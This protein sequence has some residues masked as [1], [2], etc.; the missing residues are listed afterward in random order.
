MTALYVVL[1]LLALIFILLILRVGVVL[2]YSDEG[3]LLELIVGPFSKRLH[4][5]DDEKKEPKRE[6]K[7]PKAPEKPAPEKKGGAMS[8]FQEIWAFIKKIILRLRRKFRMDE[9]I[10]HVIAAGEDP[11]KVALSYGGVSA[12]VGMIIPVLE[13]NFNIK[14]R[15]IKSD[16]SFELKEPSIFFRAKLTMA[17]WQVIY[18][19]LP[20]IRD[21]ISLKRKKEGGKEEKYGQASYRRPHGS[22]PAQH[23]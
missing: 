8:G 15:D 16:F 13:Q 18:V 4:P 5:S 1:A 6:K 12:A 9:L 11:V 23:P 7:P 2:E 22:N 14:K 17:V 19:G 20:A 3:F 10:L 21:Y